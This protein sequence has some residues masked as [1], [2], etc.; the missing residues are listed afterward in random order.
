MG[1]F[2]FQRERERGGELTSGS[3]SGDHRLQ[4]LGHHHRERER[5]VATREKSN[6]RKRLGEGAHGEGTGARGTRA[7][8]GRAGLHHES[9]PRGTHNHRPGN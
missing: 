1:T 8:L 6:E 5:E 4:K 7:E 2:P 3:K 9:K